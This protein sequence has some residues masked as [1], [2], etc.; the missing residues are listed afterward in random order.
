MRIVRTFG[1]V[2]SAAPTTPTDPTDPTTPTT[3]TR[4]PPAPPTE[5][6]KER[7]WSVLKA[8]G[9]FFLNLLLAAAFT[10]GV[11]L[12]VFWALKSFVF[13]SN[14][15]LDFWAKLGVKFFFVIIFF[16]F[17]D[18]LTPDKSQ[19][20]KA[21]PFAIIM[22]F[23]FLVVK[24]YGQDSPGELEKVMDKLGKDKNVEAALQ[25]SVYPVLTDTTFALKPGYQ[26]NW[27]GI[28]SNSIYDIDVND[29]PYTIYYKDGTVIH[30][31]A[32][33]EK[34]LPLK[35]QVIFRVSSTIGQKFT[36]TV[37]PKKLV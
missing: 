20:S 21:I 34:A 23:A 35:E 16:I 19:F 28:P 18:R 9:R 3:P 13:F 7:D 36:I 30:V 22:V 27:L 2:R 11:C 31:E 37:K 32:G 5:P 6:E 26:S 1:T 4:N 24:H 29:G 12:L 15:E 8:I 10:A 17:L 14:P 25:A 33:K